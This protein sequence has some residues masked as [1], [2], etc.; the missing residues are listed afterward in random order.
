MTEPVPRIL[1]L[2]LKEHEPFEIGAMLLSIL[3]FPGR[4]E[5]KA[6]KMAAEAL[7]ANVLRETIAADPAHTS[8]WQAAYPVYTTIDKSEIRRRLRMLERRLRDRKVA[9]RMSLGFFQEGISQEAARLPA[10]MVCLSLNELSELVQSQSG[11]SDPEN[12]ERRAWHDSR[13][14]IHLATSMQVVARTF[15]PD[16]STFGIP[17]DIP[18]L[19]RAMIGL[20]EFYAKIVLSDRRF[21]VRPEDLI[22]IRLTSTGTRIEGF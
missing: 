8:D 22:R 12:V 17:L 13:P 5:Q 21:G 1:I 2:D 11:W 16:Q 20:S 4:T 9:S 18:S 7:C 14:V 15:A 3:G 10:S 6:V 19:N